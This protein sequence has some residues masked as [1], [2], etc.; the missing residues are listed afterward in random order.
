[1]AFCP[2]YDSPCPQSNECAIW[3]DF[4]CCIVDKPGKT[5][6]YS[7]GEEPVNVFILGIYFANAKPAG[8]ILIIYADATTGVIST[9]D[10]LSDFKISILTTNP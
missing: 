8:D 3:T 6:I 9:S 5:A 4:G 7:G 1:M 2:F 10:T